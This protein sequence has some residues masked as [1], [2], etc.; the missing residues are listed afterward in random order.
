MRP[1]CVDERVSDERRV[2][3]QLCEH[4]D[5]LLRA[6]HRKP[7]LP[8]DVLSDDVGPNEADIASPAVYALGGGDVVGTR[9]EVTDSEDVGSRGSVHGDAVEV[10]CA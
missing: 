8:N 6:R 1:H 3:A 7:V 2:L 5:G 10:L 9:V 4:G